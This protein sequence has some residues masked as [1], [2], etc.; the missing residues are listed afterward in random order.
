MNFQCRKANF[1]LHVINRLKIG[2]FYTEMSMSAIAPIGYNAGLNRTAGPH[3]CHQMMILFRFDSL[4][5]EILK[6]LNLQKGQRVL[7]I[8][9]GFGGAAFIMAEVNSICIP[10]ICIENLLSLFSVNVRQYRISH[11]D[12]ITFSFTRQY[13]RHIK[14]VHYLYNTCTILFLTK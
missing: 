1:P 11:H 6:L 8:G 2:R 13:K 12:I 5:Q 10:K 3:Y 4:T 14:I 7:D 9:S